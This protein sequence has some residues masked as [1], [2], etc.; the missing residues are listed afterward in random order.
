M[1]SEEFVGFLLFLMMCVFMYFG[2][3]MSLS[4][5]ET[6][7]AEGRRINRFVAKT[8][9]FVFVATIGISLILLVI[10]VIR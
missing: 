8:Y 7:A 5:D 3:R 9:I 4:K 2:H 6:T 1:Y 10:A